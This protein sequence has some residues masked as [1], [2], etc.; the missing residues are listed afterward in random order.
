VRAARCRT[1][2][3]LVIVTAT[4]TA[5]TTVAES[6]GGDPVPPPSLELSVWAELPI[7]EPIDECPQLTPQAL[8]LADSREFERRVDHPHH[9]PTRCASTTRGSWSS[10]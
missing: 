10:A 7:D 6:A 2:I 9:P 1:V 3:L 8:H 5:M 4:A